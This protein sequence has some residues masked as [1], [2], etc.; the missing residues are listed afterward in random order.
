MPFPVDVRF[1]EQVEE[2]V[3]MRF[4][5]AYRQALLRDNGGEVEIDEDWFFDLYPV[6]DDSEPVRLKRTWDDIARQT[7]Q[8]RQLPGFPEGAVV[9]GHDGSG[10]LLVLVASTGN[11]PGV[12][13][14][15]HETGEVEAVE[16]DPFAG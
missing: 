14:W 10:D 9:I 4:P 12:A 8:A 6:K 5:E 15:N 7:E 2:S 3:S 13:V 1:V 11:E 16:R